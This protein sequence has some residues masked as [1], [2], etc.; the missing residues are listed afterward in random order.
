MSVVRDKYRGTK[1]YSLVQSELIVAAQYRGVVTYQFLARKLG[2]P[3]TGNLMGSRIGHLLG[4]ISED[5]V[6]HGRPMLSALA[7]SSKFKPSD[8]FFDLACS[9]K[10]LK[11]NSKEAE[12]LFWQS[13]R[14]R[15]YEVWK[16]VLRAAPGT[17]A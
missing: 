12:E 15:C 17:N 16:P 14:E 1:E 2:W 8:G 7:V 6:F 3:L 10:K 4:E 11:G 5:E 13:E 9:L